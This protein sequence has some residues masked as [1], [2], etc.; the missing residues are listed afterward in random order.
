MDLNQI[1]VAVRDLAEALAFY[2][3]VGFK[4]IVLSKE[5]RYAR[6]EL[7][8]GSTTFSVHEDARPDAGNATLY[9]EVDDIDRR[10]GELTAAGILFE[11]PPAYQP[12]RWREARFLD[13]TG[14]RFC[15]YHAGPDRRFPPWRLTGHLPPSFADDP[16]DDSP[17]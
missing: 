3:K 1:S 9:L 17:V 10:Y 16:E 2:G 6:F 12:W 14:N 13:P 7:P 15:L 11:S 5:N 4:L 8:S